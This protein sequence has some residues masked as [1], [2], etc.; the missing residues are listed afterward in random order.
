MPLK[1]V[2]SDLDGTILETEDYHRKAYN[3]LFEEL[4]LSKAWAREDYVARLQTMG[5]DKFKEI[6]GWLKLPVETFEKTKKELYHRKTQ[7]YVDLIERDLASGNLRMRPG[8]ER[9]FGELLEKAV[10]LAIGTACVGWAAERVIRAA[11]GSDFFDRLICFC[12][13]ESTPRK[14]PHPDI[15][16]LVARSVSIDPSDC[17]VLEDT[18]H[19]VEAAKKAGMTCIA[20]PSEFALEHDFSSADLNVPNLDHPP[21]VN[22]KRLTGMLL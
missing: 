20:T 11:L 13:G 22:L 12:G 17:L 1:L 18:K 2:I 16:L 4:Q 19:G 21:A 14:K 10:P 6:F 3:A 8:V 15:Y 7:L 9:L 5:G